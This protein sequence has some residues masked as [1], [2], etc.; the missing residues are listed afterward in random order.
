MYSIPC[1]P[2]SLH[3][4]Y[5]AVF[6]TFFQKEE[7]KRGWIICLGVNLKNI[8]KILNVGKNHRHK[9]VYRSCSSAG[10]YPVGNKH[11]HRHTHRIN[12]NILLNHCWLILQ[13][14][15][16]SLWNLLPWLNFSFVDWHFACHF[17]LGLKSVPDSKSMML[18][19]EGAISIRSIAQALI[20]IPRN[21]VTKLYYSF[22]Y[23]AWSCKVPDASKK[24]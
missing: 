8:L 22:W 1:K 10:H 15:N 11:K 19:F 20:I 17:S 2:F 4:L 24:C 14:G 16:Q 5:K 12:W 18:N 3:Y 6:K 9:G 13:Q 7:T 21:D 23:S